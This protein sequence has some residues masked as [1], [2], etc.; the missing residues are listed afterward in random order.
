MSAHLTCPA[1]RHS[2]EFWVL[3]DGRV[4]CADE[5]CHEVLCLVSA[6]SLAEIRDRWGKEG[7]AA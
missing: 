4:I 6:A 1:C 3:P 7:G 5:D 2:A